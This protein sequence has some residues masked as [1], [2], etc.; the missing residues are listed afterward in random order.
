MTKGSDL[1]RFHLKTEEYGWLSNF[2]PYPVTID[3]V[4]WPTVEH[5]YQASKFI[6]DPD[7]MEAILAIRRPY[8]AWRMGRNPDHLRRSDWDQIKDEVMLRAVRAKFKQHENL[9]RFLLATGDATLVENS[10]TDEYWGVGAAH[11]GQN[12]L[13][14]ILMEVRQQLKQ[15]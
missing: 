13:G 9:A 6:H 1:I 15:V 10:A 7:W 4:A 11:K 14:K 8:D 12:R 5:Y 2:A 3:A